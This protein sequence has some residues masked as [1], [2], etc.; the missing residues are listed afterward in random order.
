VIQQVRVEWYPEGAGGAQASGLSPITDIIDLKARKGLDIKNNILDLTLKNANSKYV[1]VDGDLLFDSNDILVVYMQTTTDATDLTSE[2]WGDDN[3]IGYYYVAEYTQNSN[4]NGFRLKL[5]A[6]DKAYILF[7]KVFAKSYGATTTDIWTSPGIFRSVVR[8]NSFNQK[9]A[10]LGTHNESGVNFDVSANFA[11]EGGYIEDR[12]TDLSLTLD[13]ALDSSATTI[14]L[15]STTGLQASGGTVVINSEHIYYAGISGATITGCVR[16]IDDTVAVAHD[17]ATVVY[18]GFPILNYSKI[19]KPIYEWLSDLGQTQN[20][21]YNSE[22]LSGALRFDRAFMIWIDSKN[23]IHYVPTTDTVDRNLTIG[24]DWIFEESLE[25]SVFD[26]VNM[27]IYNVGEDMYG[28]GVNWYY[29]D[30]NT[31]VTELKMRYQPMTEI[32]E[33]ILNGEYA[34]YPARY[35]AATT[36]SSNRRFPSSYTGLTA[37]TFKDDGNAFRTQVLHLTARTQ[38][39][40]ASDYNNSLREAAQWRGRN[41]AQQITTRL[42]GLRY[43]GTITMRGTHINPGDLIL[44][45][46]AKTGIVNQK[47]RVQDVTQTLTKSQWSSNISVSEDEKVVAQWLN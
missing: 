22:L 18:E 31:S 34:A 20:T 46:D 13:G 7:N 15:S 40:N 14:T 36:G 21:N 24:S 9:G 11:S 42:A 19:W 37:W 39:T 12:R 10:H 2:W 5:N 41:Q 29:Y 26:S 16:G 28:A 33:T 1:D 4:R 32:T 6:V 3:L 38:I 45:N 35:P 17:T 47:L 27:V 25:K 8:I 44:V 23:E 43:K 30:E